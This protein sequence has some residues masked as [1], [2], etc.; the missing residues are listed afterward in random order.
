M[1]PGSRGLGRNHSG[2][3]LVSLK[4]RL[5][6]Q[7]CKSSQNPASDE[8]VGSREIL[9]QV[10]SLALP[11]T[12]ALAVEPIGSLVST[13]FMGHVGSV[14]LAGVGVSLSVYN[15]FTKLFNMPLLAIITSTIGSA[16]GYQG[17]D[18]AKVSDAILSS[19]ALA[20]FIGI[21]QSLVL[22][23]SGNVGLR[24]YGATPGSD[25]FKPASQYLMVRTLGNCATV[26]FVSLLGIFRGLGDTVSPLI[27]T[28][29]FTCSSI[30]FEYMFLFSFGWGAQG[31]ALAVV[32]AQVV[33]GCV[34]LFSLSRSNLVSF[35]SLQERRKLAINRDHS[36]GILHRL[37]LTCILMWRT[38]AVMLVYA[39]ACGIL[40]RFGGA[41]VTAAHQI[42]FQIWLASSLLSDSL[43]VA[44]QSLISRYR[45]Q[46]EMGKAATV[47]SVG[48][49]LAIILGCILTVFLILVSAVAPQNL[50]SSDIDVLE[51]L[52]A[53][54]P[55]VIGS[56]V[57]NSIAFVM[58]GIV[59]GYGRKGFVYAA[60][61]MIFAAI[62][63][64][65]T[66]LG[67]LF[68]C[69]QKN[70]GPICI[71]QSVWAGLL[72]LMVC[73]SLTMYFNRV[74]SL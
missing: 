54:M 31:A 38:L 65:A 55:L 70:L 3:A 5:L 60:K 27:G 18:R 66:M 35:E 63:S 42:A 17:S 2:G 73:R 57:V 62:P 64:I 56:Q 67:G 15:A 61:S 74:S 21:S 53:I 11:T 34:Q 4:R 72:V 50:F 45:G 51:A 20:L 14:E 49:Q 43:A 44:S 39:T 22:Y 16:T 71:L 36:A 1:L 28:L 47:A 8:D 23:V 25:I 13:G 69:L 33:G 26:S 58:D 48:F 9:R 30:M 40:A 6:C 29:C 41:T 68:F 52:E 7:R 46:G 24:M 19:L 37:G 59:Y 32:L 12:L 10:V